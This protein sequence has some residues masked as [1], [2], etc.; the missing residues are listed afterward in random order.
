MDNESFIGNYKKANFIK[1]IFISFTDFLTKTGVTGIGYDG[2]WVVDIYDICKTLSEHCFDYNT[3]DYDYDVLIPA[4]LMS[5]NCVVVE[6]VSHS[7]NETHEG[8]SHEWDLM[9]M[10]YGVV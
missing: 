2:Y 6:E 1:N 4:I 3:M 8:N 10:N 7:L 5:I 9:F